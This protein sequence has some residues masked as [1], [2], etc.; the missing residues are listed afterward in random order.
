V[1][2][3]AGFI[4]T[5]LRN[6]PP[7]PER[8]FRILLLLTLSVSAQTIKPSLDQLSFM[9]GCWAFQSGDVET[10]KYWTKPE[11]GTM[12][13]LS[14][15][16]KGSR[17]SFIE[18]TQI[19]EQNG[20]LSKFVQLGLTKSQTEFRLTKLAANEVVFT[21][22][23]ENPKH[24]IYRRKD[25]G[26]LFGRIEGTKNGQAISQTIGT[27]QTQVPIFNHDNTI[28]AKPDQEGLNGWQPAQHN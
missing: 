1:A 4:F 27:V 24:L 28:G 7:E 18:Y 11:G 20:A 17:T 8:M 2:P 5:G 10:E 25:D 6:T 15:T 12:A 13:G 3:A 23:L 22:D 19:R 9:T 14:R 26:S 21:S 16:V